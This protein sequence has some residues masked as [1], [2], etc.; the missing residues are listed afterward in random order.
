MANPSTVIRTE[1]D[2]L[3][4]LLALSARHLANNPTL[5]NAMRQPAAAGGDAG[6][7]GPSGQTQPGGP[8]RRFVVG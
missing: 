6:V 2:T 1:F 7:Y 5:L 4:E 3:S 8:S